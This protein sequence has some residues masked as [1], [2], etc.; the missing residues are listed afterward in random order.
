MGWREACAQTLTAACAKS[1]SDGKRFEHSCSVCFHT[2]AGVQGLDLV[3]APLERRIRNLCLGIARDLH[4]AFPVKRKGVQPRLS[5]DP[6]GGNG[7]LRGAR[8]DRSMQNKS[9]K[10]GVRNSYA[11]E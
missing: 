1:N 5:P 9:I 11:P 2:Y 6:R 7:L 8:S 3:F 10:G 4:G